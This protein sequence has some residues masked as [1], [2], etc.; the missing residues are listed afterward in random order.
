MEL[1]A[2]QANSTV[3]SRRFLTL[4]YIQ[5]ILCISSSQAYSLVRS[6]EIRAIRVGGRGQ[7][8]VEDR[9]LESFIVKSYFQPDAPDAID[10]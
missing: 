10:A 5:E 6:N 1:S 7:W 3:H 9:D 8:R 2:M 4:D